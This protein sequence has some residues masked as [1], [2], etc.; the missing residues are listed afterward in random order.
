[1]E[2]RER[3]HR[4]LEERKRALA[5]GRMVRKEEVEIEG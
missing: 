4:G 2:Q 3:A 1:M 5:R